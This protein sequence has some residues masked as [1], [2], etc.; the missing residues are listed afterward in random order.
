[1]DPSWLWVGDMRLSTTLLLF[2]FL[3]VGFLHRDFKA[4]ILAALTWLLR[5]YCGPPRS[6]ATND[7]S[8]HR[9]ASSPVL[10]VDTRPGLADIRAPLK[11]PN[12]GSVP[13]GKGGGL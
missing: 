10:F 5:V 7:S 6:S 11:F 13:S 12:R 2:A 1:M 3:F 8:K 9:R 4:A